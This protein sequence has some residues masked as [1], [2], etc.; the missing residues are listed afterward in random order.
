MTVGY[1]WLIDAKKCNQ[2]ALRDI[3]LLRNVFSLVISDLELKTL[4][5]GIWHKFAGEGGITGMVMLTE[6]H[7][8]CHTYPEH[9]TATFNLYC[10]RERPEWDW[11]NKLIQLLGA[12]MVS[13]EQI[14]RGNRQSQVAKLQT[15]FDGVSAKVKKRENELSAAQAELKDLR[16]EL[17]NLKADMKTAKSQ[18]AGGEH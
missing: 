15:E 17:N 3:D 11:E 1:E 16:G 13:V 7:L 2:E 12:Q 8:T 4:G 5:E 6:S 9:G 14:E 18:N 10:C